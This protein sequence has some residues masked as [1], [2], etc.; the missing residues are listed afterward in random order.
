MDKA[1]YVIY[2]YRDAAGNCQACDY[3]RDMDPNHQAKSKRVFVAL[4][5]L[6]P[7]IP[8]EYGKFL[9]DGIWELRIIISHHQHRL[10]YFYRGNAIVVT[11]AF[12]EKSQE[13]PERE[14]EISRKA[15]VDWLA[16]RGWEEL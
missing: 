4:S 5:E 1:R 6:V 12:L 16:S 14:M 15:R 3:A 8:G 10:L 7:E 13:V 11:N 2:F 9:R